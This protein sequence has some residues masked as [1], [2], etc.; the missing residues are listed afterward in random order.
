METSKITPDEALNSLMEGNSR[1]SSGHPSHPHQSIDRRID[2]AKNGQHP[3]AAVLYCSDSRS[4]VEQIFDQGNGD[5]FGVRVAGNIATDE[6]I[7]SMEYAVDHLGV[8]LVMILGHT[9]CGAVDA[10]VK[11]G[12]PHGHIGSLVKA[13]TPSLLKAKSSASHPEDHDE[14]AA[15]TVI[16]NIE[17]AV[18]AIKG[19]EIISALLEKETVKVVG[20]VYNI[21]SG[22]VEI[23]K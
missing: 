19:S 3:I 20:A 8:P 23:S 11:G 12:T 16:N 17:A 9:K 1:F 13:I 4:P 7:G 10:T 22:V 21:E 6:N 5:I 14:V 2:L 15:L 18:A